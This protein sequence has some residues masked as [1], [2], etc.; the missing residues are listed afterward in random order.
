VWNLSDPDMNTL[1]FQSITWTDAGAITG[2]AAAGGKYFRSCIFN[3]CAQIDFSTVEVTD[4][5]FNGTT[6]ALGAIILNGGVSPLGS[7]T[8][9]YSGLIFNSDGAGHAVYITAPGTYELVGWQ[10]N[11]YGG[12]PE[13]NAAIYNNSGG[14][15]T[16]NISGAGDTPTIRNGAGASTVINNNVQVTITNIQPGTEV[17]VYTVESPINTTAIAG[18]EST[19]S[20][21]EFTFSAAAGQIVDI[22]VFNI[23]YVLP[24]DNRI[25]NFQVPTAD[26]SFPISQI[27]DRNY[28]NP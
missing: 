23:D 24:P 12:S 28:F 16:L 9:N 18:V 10:F 3:N 27:V 20:P 6:D 11:G 22:V 25:R 14:L 8:D 26:T 4:C 2:P 21:S 13:A 15:V 7:K 17:R 1:A 19:G 5:I